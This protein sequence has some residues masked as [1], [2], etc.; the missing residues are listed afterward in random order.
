MLLA[1][2]VDLHA[3]EGQVLAHLGVSGQRLQRVAL[4]LGGQGI[5]GVLQLHVRVEGVVLGLYGLLAV[6]V[7]EREVHTRLLGQQAAQVYVRGDGI[8]DVVL[9][10]A[11]HHALFDASEAGRLHLGGYVDRADVGKLHVQVA[12][13]GPSALVGELLQAQL[14]APHLH[15]LHRTAIVPDAYHNGLHLA[16]RRVA[17]DGDAVAGPFL[18]VVGEELCHAY[19]SQ[20]LLRIARLLQAGKDVQVD[21]YHVLLRPYGSA[22]GSALGVVEAFGSQLHRHFILVEVALVVGTQSQEDARLAVGYIRNV[23]GQGI[24]VEEHLQVLVL[25]HIVGAVLID[26]AGVAGTQIAHYH[27]HCLLV[28][29]HQLCLVGVGY[30]AYAGRQHVVD[31]LL[32]VVLLDI[33]GADLQGA[34]RS[35][36][37]AHV[38]LL[39]V[40]APVAVHKVQGGQPEDDILLET[41]H[42]HAHEADAGEVVDVALLL[43]VFVQGHAE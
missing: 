10:G 16:Q 23:L 34:A 36:C 19:Q 2:D 21:V 33:D 37:L 25:A 24:G 39:L 4:L 26:G 9:V 3:A 29:L 30:S 7:V 15:A 18:V 14:V 40:G 38:E 31:G 12:L 8:V 11:A 27:G 13:R 6:A 41:S 17:H 43:L 5:H 35:R 42:E 28:V 1:D 22:S 20:A 32:V